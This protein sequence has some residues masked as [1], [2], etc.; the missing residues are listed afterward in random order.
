YSRKAFAAAS[1]ASLTCAEPSLL[2]SGSRALLV[3][4]SMA[5]IVPSV[6]GTA[7]PAM[8]DIPLSVCVMA[9]FLVGCPVSAVSGWA[10]C[11]LRGWVPPGQPDPA[12]EDPGEVCAPALHH[13]RSP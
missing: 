10:G 2:N 4:G 11:Q 5:L 3:L 1:V 13:N 7:R 8:I 12:D 6:P 9:S